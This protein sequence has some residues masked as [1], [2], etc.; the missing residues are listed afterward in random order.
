MDE[1]FDDSGSLRRFDMAL[2]LSFAGLALI[3][4]A[5]G[6]YG[7]IAYSVSQRTREIA[8]RMAVGAQR[9]DVLR[10]VLGQGAKLACV[11]VIAGTIGSLVLSK[12]MASLLYEVNPRDLLTF[13]T[14]PLILIAVI[15]L[16]CYL[17]ARRAA[18]VQ[19]NTALRY[20]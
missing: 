16:A 5:I 10:L 2:L 8:I 20:E 4:S 19:P 1:M 18:A 15:L 14:V 12:V 9:G 11:G 6:V 17:P 13:S 3:L 7:V